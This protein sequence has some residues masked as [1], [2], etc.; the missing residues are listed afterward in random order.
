MG[1]RGW[2]KS[3]VC[4]KHLRRRSKRCSRG[5]PRCSAHTAAIASHA[6]D[7]ITIFNVFCLWDISHGSDDFQQ[8]GAF[9]GGDINNI[10]MMLG[11]DQLDRKIDA[12]EDHQRLMA[13]AFAHQAGHFMQADSYEHSAV[14]EFLMFSGLSGNTHLGRHDA[15][16][17]NRSSKP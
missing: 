8:F 4:E 9:T 12:G 1:W 2:R 13:V 15:D 5:G 17:M 7:S 14:E 6:T 3:S 11:F 16:V 10:C